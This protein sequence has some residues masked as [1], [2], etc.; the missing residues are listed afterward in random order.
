MQ[1]SIIHTPHSFLFIPLSFI[2]AHQTE[3]SSLTVF[4]GQAVNL[5]CTPG[6]RMA[7]IRWTFNGTDLTS[8]VD[9]SSINLMPEGLHHQLVIGQPTV[10]DSG[11]YVC[12]INT[13]VG[14]PALKTITLTV[15]PGNS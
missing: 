10:V 2:I 4:E 5:Q 15:I 8:R 11:V 1:T 6:I 9:R 14:R 13:D 3:S 7:S 12:Y